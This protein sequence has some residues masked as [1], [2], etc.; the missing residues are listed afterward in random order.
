[1]SS[2]DPVSESARGY[3]SLE[4]KRRFTIVAG[5]LGAVFFLAQFIL[6]FLFMFLVMMPTM[7][8]GAIANVDID[9][10]ALWRDELWFIEQTAKVNWRDPENSATSATLRHVKLMDLEHTGPAIALEVDGKDASPALLPIGDRLW[11]IGAE[12]VSYYE[13]GRLIPLSGGS[14]PARASRPFAH[15]GRPAVITVGGSPTLA[16]LAAEGGRAEW[17]VRPFPLGLPPEAGSLRTLQA[18]EMSGRLHLIAEL[19]TEEPQQCSL[20]Y[21]EAER[22]TW[23]PLFTDG[24]ACASW[25]AMAWRSLPA[26]VVSDRQDGPALTVITIKGGGTER[27]RIELA[28]KKG[29]DLRRWRALPLGDRLLLASTG[30]PGSLTLGELA[31][32]RVV[33]SVKK[34]GSFPFGS[35][36]MLFMLVP[37]ALPLLLSL[38]L[39]ILLTGQMRRHRVPDYVLGGSR[40][41]FATLWQRALAQ[42]VDA[43]PLVA[44]FL[45][46]MLWMWRMFSDPEEFLEERGFA[47]MFWFFGLFAA[48]FVSA[49]L[50]LVAYSYFEGRFGKT[51]GKW[52]LG[53]RVLGTDLRPCGFGR[54]LLRNLLTVVDGFLN[55]LVG[56]LLVALT[57]NWQRLGDLAART[58]VLVDETPASARAR[59][60]T[61]EA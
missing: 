14:R 12:R 25:N 42:L 49:L 8:G 28:G 56:V 30:M 33:R 51:P 41:S 18:V 17:N 39:A 23:V 13:S 59:S 22:E 43:V 21:R 24:C 3:L 32:G 52:L 15:Q 27:Q 46:P 48:A 2:A 29:L 35:N 45:L 10:A 7:M 38:A 53:I 31:D 5:V 61:S 44:G 47:S 60:R 57:E 4:S 54:A 16:T 58:V 1:M 6:P 40:R 50:V 11:L 9:Q 36:M 20:S 34:A 19:C 37:N 26:V 55:F